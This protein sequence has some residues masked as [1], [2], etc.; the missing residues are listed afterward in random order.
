MLLGTI[1]T[2]PDLTKIF[3]ESWTRQVISPVGHRFGNRQFGDETKLVHFAKTKSTNWGIRVG[4]IDFSAR[5][6]GP[7][8][9]FPEG[10]EHS[11]AVLILQ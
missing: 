7:W 2:G 10:S 9:D 5:T 3:S 6:T 1:S 4:G 11:S 8:H